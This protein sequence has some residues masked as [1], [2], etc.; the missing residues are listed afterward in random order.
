MAVQLTGGYLPTDSITDRE[1]NA[2]A[3]IQRTK[4]LLYQQQKVW[5]PPTSWRVWDAFQ[6][7]L[8]GTA[9][10]DDLAL[11]GQ[12]WATGC[13]QLQSSDAGGTT[14]T[15]RART[16][17]ALPKE[18]V[19]SE[20]VLLMFWAGM[21]GA[22]S[23]SATLDVEVYRVGDNGLVDGSDLYTGAAVDINSTTFDDKTFQLTDSALGPGDFIDVRITVAITDVGGSNKIAKIPKV[24][25]L[26]D[27]Q[28]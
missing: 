7:T 5:I 2:N 3:G 11:V 18:Y 1:I 8:P 4:L 21:Q 27:C 16:V 13:P 28:G 22:A 20:N 26:A 25:L 9:A 10:A 15:Q 19:A 23:A 14:V 12:T 6:T 17:I 24:W